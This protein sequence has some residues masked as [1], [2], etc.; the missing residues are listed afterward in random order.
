[1]EP[2]ELIVPSCDNA[3]IK[4]AVFR[5]YKRGDLSRFAVNTYDFESI[6]QGQKLDGSEIIRNHYFTKANCIISKADK[7][8]AVS[9]HKYNNVEKAT[10][11]FDDHDDEALVIE[12]KNTLDETEFLGELKSYNSLVITELTMI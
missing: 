2:D 10:F 12:I 11:S 1:M 6:K 8:F 3:D 7:L 5:A 4:L 9:V